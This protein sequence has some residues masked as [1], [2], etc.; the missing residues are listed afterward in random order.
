[1]GLQ[2]LTEL[3]LVQSRKPCRFFER[4]SCRHNHQ[5]E[6]ITRADLLETLAD[7]NATSDPGMQGA[8][9]Q[10]AF[11]LWNQSDVPRGKHCIGKRGG[12]PSYLAKDAMCA[13]KGTAS[14]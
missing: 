14:L 10:G 7:R 4:M 9:R 2:Q 1:M 12:C 6:Q 13:I 11:P 8:R 3:G 5:K